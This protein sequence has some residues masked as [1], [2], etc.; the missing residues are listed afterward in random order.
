MTVS[1]TNYGRVTTHEGTLAE[2]MAAMS[3]VN[4]DMIISI[5]GNSDFTKIIGIHRYNSQ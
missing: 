4:P 3:E 2:V 5:F 1:T